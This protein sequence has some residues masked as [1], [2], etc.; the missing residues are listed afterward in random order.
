MNDDLLNSFIHSEHPHYIHTIFLYILHVPREAHIVSMYV[1]DT[2]EL[3]IH[4]IF[5]VDLQTLGSGRIWCP[6]PSHIWQSLSTLP[7][8]YF[9]QHTRIHIKC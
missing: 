7:N 1:E 2:I 3:Y 4:H 8:V 9:S 5:N 6:H